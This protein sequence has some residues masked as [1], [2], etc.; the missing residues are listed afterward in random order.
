MLFTNAYF[1]LSGR[2]IQNSWY[3]FFKLLKVILFFTLGFGFLLPPGPKQKNGIETD[4][5]I[6]RTN[7]RDSKVTPPKSIKSPA[8]YLGQVSRI[9][10][11]RGFTF[12]GC[13]T[14]G[15]ENHFFGN[16]FFAETKIVF[17]AF[18]RRFAPTSHDITFKFQMNC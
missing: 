16:F 7:S 2:R 8:L 6:Q 11:G 17:G 4:V 9:L 13:F 5:G 12:V 1:F 3:H 15:R 10:R 18:L 14:F